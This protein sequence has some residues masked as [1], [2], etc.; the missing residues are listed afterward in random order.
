[1]DIN[2]RIIELR[3]EGLGY[4][5]IA[6]ELGISRD[7]VRSICLSNGLGGVKGKYKQESKPREN[8]SKPKFKK[9]CKECEQTYESTRNLIKLK[10]T[11]ENGLL[12]D[13]IIHEINL[14]KE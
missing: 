1:M 7:K 8:K 10:L 5:V 3:N 2:H 13:C 11:K 12:P 6:K 14:I 9:T 4:K